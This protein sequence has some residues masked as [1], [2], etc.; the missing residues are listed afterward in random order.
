MT[1]AEKLSKSVRQKRPSRPVGRRVVWKC[2]LNEMRHVLNLTLRDIEGAISV[3]S[4]VLSTIEHGTDPQ[5][6]TARRIAD[7]FGCTVE[8]MW[9]ALVDSQ[10]KPH[11][12]GEV[13]HV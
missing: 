9:P 13:S 1:K 11:G 5:L 2:K 4:A 6:T 10:V 12:A 7:F 8:E 3:S